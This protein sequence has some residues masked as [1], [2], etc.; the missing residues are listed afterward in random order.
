MVICYLLA[1]IGA[2]TTVAFILW[3]MG[4]LPGG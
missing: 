2:V 1:A 3:L 4:M